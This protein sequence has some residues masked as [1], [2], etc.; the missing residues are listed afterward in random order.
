MT[1][2]TTLCLN[3]SKLWLEYQWLLSGHGVYAVMQ[4]C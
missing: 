4:R 1:K 2:I 3:M